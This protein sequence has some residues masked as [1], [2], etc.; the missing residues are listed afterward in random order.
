MADRIGQQLDKYRITRLLG[1]GGFADVYLGEHIYLKTPAAIKILQTRLSGSDDL[2]SFLQ[3]A[4]FIAQLSHP[5]IV[6]VL[7]FGVHEET[8]FLVME[9]APNGTL[10][11]RHSSGTVLPLTTITSYVKQVAN[12]LQYAHSEKLVHR[13]IKPENMLVGRRNDVLLSD[14]GIALIAQS[15]RYQSTQDV[16]GTI[17]YMSPEQIQGKPRPASDQYALGIVVYEWLCGDRPF[18]G[19]FTELCAQH[20]FASPPPLRERIATISQDVEHV[21]MTAL[22]KDPKHRFSSV[23]AFANALEQASQSAPKV[24]ISS[25]PQP[26]SQPPQ[27]VETPLLAPIQNKPAPP[28]APTQYEPT[29]PL[30]PTQLASVVSL[31]ETNPS[32]S[33]SS[34]Q[35]RPVTQ[36]P[37]AYLRPTTG[38]SVVQQPSLAPQERGK[39]WSIGKRQIVAMCIGIVLHAS[40]FR[41]SPTFFGYNLLFRFT[42]PVFFGVVFGPW[43]G[44]VVGGIGEVVGQV[45]FGR[46]L[47]VIMVGVAL[48]GF[49]SGLSMLKTQGQYTLGNAVLAG[50]I[51]TAGLAI[52]IGFI[53]ATLNI[54]GLFATDTLG[55]AII[56][57]IIFP[58]L[59]LIYKI[60]NRK[61]A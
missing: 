23:L 9:Y 30:V 41:V 29:P 57:L 54:F 44:L 20:M 53:L 5:H 58:V 56:T 31:P 3:E 32:T 60:A 25:P 11:E 4:R 36:P 49:I 1:R 28:P 26:T 46:F 18:H 34:S 35:E 48:T 24:A 7:D 45:L 52:G 2:E 15:S 16:T 42:V 47:W 17:S 6:R 10:R 37:Q 8:P 61:K 38:S 14:F 27:S 12:A 13:D 51:G 59:L 22:A 50:V 21:V 55:D 33:S 40:L 39:V 43:V 19:S